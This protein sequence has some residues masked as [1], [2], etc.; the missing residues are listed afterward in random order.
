MLE[1]FKRFYDCFQLETFSETSIYL[2]ADITAAKVSKMVER[3]KYERGTATMI[4][5][6]TYTYD[7]KKHLTECCLR[8][9]L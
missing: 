2:S 3:Y 1:I 8:V 5:M 6:F 4:T 7:S 9:T